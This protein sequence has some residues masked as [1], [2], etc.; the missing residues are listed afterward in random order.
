MGM[1]AIKE[2]C[3]INLITWILR[4]L[5]RN[6]PVLA[7]WQ[8]NGELKKIGTKQM[9]EWFEEL[10]DEAKER[11]ESSM[12]SDMVRLSEKEEELLVNPE[13]VS[14][15]TQARA[16]FK[17]MTTSPHPSGVPELPFPLSVMSQKMKTKYISNQ[18]ASEAKKDRVRLVYGGDDWRPSFWLEEVWC[19]KSVQKALRRYTEALFSGEGSFSEFLDRTIANIF[20]KKDLNTETHVFELEKKAEI[21]KKRERSRGIHKPPSI[22]R[23]VNNEEVVS[24]DL[25]VERSANAS[26]VDPTCDVQS[27]TDNS[28]NLPAFNPRRPMRDSPFKNSLIQET[29]KASSLPNPMASLQ[30][31]E[32][33]EVVKYIETPEQ[34][35]HE[36]EDFKV[37]FN[38]GGG[39]CLFKAASQH[40]DSI[41]PDSVGSYKEFRR[42]C[43]KK[44]LQWWCYFHQFYSWPM[45]MTIGTGEESKKISI[46]S[47]E[48]FKQFLESDSSLESFNETEVELWVISYI[49]NT[50]VCVLSYNLPDGQG[51]DGS[52]YKWSYFCGQGV[53]QDAENER[54]SCGSN[55]LFLLNEH[56]QHW[57]RLVEVGVS[58]SFS[59]NLEVSISE[60]G[61][62][63]AEGSAK[64]VEK[65]KGSNPLKPRKRKDHSGRTE[66]KT[67]MRRKNVHDDLDLAN[68]GLES[69]ELA[70][71]KEPDVPLKSA[72]PL[73]D[74]QNENSIE[75]IP[76]S[77]G[78]NASIRPRRAKRGIENPRAKIMKS[79]PK[80]TAAKKDEVVE[81]KSCQGS[82]VGVQVENVIKDKNNNLAVALAVKTDMYYVFHLKEP[83]IDDLL[84]PPTASERA[85]EA[86]LDLIDKEISDSSSKFEA[87]MEEVTKSTEQ[88]NA[89]QKAR[90]KRFRE[91]KIR[92]DKME[93]EVSYSKMKELFQQNKDYIMKVFSGE[94]CTARRDA[95]MK[96]GISRDRLRQKMITPFCDHHHSAIMDELSS[97][98]MR[99]YWEEIKNS[100]FIW[101]VVL[102]ETYVKVLF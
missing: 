52:R 3:E 67:K 91:N 69:D 37:T 82:V 15:K 100:E 93:S 80:S 75:K 19:W 1:T 25:D 14:V 81:G 54:Y 27:T 66:V 98:W 85:E 31:E 8:H 23:N 51:K 2:N 41:R 6:T 99:D 33:V 49:L 24:D 88:E 39:S 20:V 64:V 44:L 60:S 70:S 61:S 11:L 35:K 26:T 58:P 101:K 12:V 53:V 10:N 72:E 7:F 48:E 89:K 29:I 30:N 92:R 50:T 86:R 36:L 79:K 55:A 38:S 18:I 40:L 22:T 28:E 34:V 16:I 47:A 71:C 59:G 87:E 63:E 43:H 13:N 32:N 4:L 76:N 9:I 97:I 5:G 95:F 46:Q 68:A 96:D 57:A 21:V 42:H 62:G 77:K 73:N 78:R 65:S 94:V 83:T 90:R 17:S 102:P 74:E 56:M 84:R 45:T